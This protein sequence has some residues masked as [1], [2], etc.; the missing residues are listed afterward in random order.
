MLGP[1]R[2]SHIE[3]CAAEVC[4]EFRKTEELQDCITNLHTLDA[5]LADHRVQLAALT[6]VDSSI[7]TNANSD[8]QSP[9]KAK[10][11][12]IVSSI[13]KAPDYKDLDLTKAK[14]LIQARERAINSVKALI[15]KKF[16]PPA[17]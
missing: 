4:K 9:S 13:K 6:D 10:G 11:P 16:K 8:M 7:A 3:T 12:S 15:A 5:L 17:T 14:R 1:A 2:F